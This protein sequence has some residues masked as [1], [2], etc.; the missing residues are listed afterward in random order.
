M[1]EYPEVATASTKL[2]VLEASGFSSLGYF[3]LPKSCW[4]DHCYQP[5]RSRFGAFQ[6]C[7]GHSAAANDIVDA[8]QHEIGSYERFTVFV[9][10]G[11]YIATRTAV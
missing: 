10:Y 8:E 4:L 3:P 5:M 11:F 9:S 2:A 1:S 7:H 6:D